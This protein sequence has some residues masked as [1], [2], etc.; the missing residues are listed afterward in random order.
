MTT[1]LTR[2]YAGLARAFWFLMA[3]L[4]IVFG[5]AIDGTSAVGHH[6]G[7]ILG[8]IFIGVGLARSRW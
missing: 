8:G 3:V 1:T 5:F 6:A 7:L 4:L 2:L